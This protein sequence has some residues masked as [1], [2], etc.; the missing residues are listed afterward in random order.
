MRPHLHLI[1]GPSPRGEKGCLREVYRTIFGQ[2]LPAVLVLLI[3]FEVQ[4][5][6]INFVNYFED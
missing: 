3:A 4:F 5:T 1:P 2:R 6:L